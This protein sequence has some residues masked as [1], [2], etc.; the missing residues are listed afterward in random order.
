MTAL[1]ASVRN[2]EECEIALRAG[3]DWIDLKEPAAGP[4]GAVSL[5]IAAEAVHIVAGRRPLS[6]TI[7]NCWDDPEKIVARVIAMAGVGMPYLKIGLFA[8]DLSERMS[9]CLAAAV[10]RGVPLIAVCFAESPPRPPDVELLSELGFTGVMLDTA[11]KSSGGLRSKVDD[12][13]IGEFVLA[14][15]RRRLLIGLAGSLQLSDIRPLYNFDIDY[16]GF[17]GAICGPSGRTGQLCPAALGRVC[18]ELEQAS[19]FA[20]ARRTTRWDG[21]KRPKNGF[22][23]MT[24]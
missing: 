23:P 20:T 7:G 13:T 9:N 21:A 6:A 12:H 17:R 8:R 24:K 18:C 1:L 22:I 10:A 15:R 2:P 19:K 16:L 4:L 11:D 14:A 3:V 5:S